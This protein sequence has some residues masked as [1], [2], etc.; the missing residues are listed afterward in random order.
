MTY[1]KDKQREYAK[2]WIKGNCLDIGCRDC[3][4]TNDAIGLDINPMWNPDIIGDIHKIPFS[5]LSFDTIF[6]SHIL[7]HTDKT[8]EVLK[9]W[10]RVLKNKGRLI[11]LV[12][13]GEDCPWQTLGDSERDHKQLFTDKTI[14]LFLRYVGFTIL[15]LKIGF[16][17]NNRR[18]ILII[19]EKNE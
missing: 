2:K 13:H 15:D 3:K 5:D 4:I 10:K 18:D 12:P 14:E 16:R 1:L 8:L 6:A 9:E 11:I 17:E 19:G 7:E